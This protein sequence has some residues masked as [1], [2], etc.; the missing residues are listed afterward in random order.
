MS[1]FD[2]NDVHKIYNYTRIN[3]T[4][5]L[6]NYFTHFTISWVRIS[7]GQVFAAWSLY[8]FFWYYNKMRGN[9]EKKFF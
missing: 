6:N 2:L 7:L 4:G 8:D 1:T 3:L 9:I 5:E